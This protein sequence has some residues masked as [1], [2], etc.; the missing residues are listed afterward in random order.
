MTST[1]TSTYHP[2]RTDVAETTAIP[3]TRTRRGWAV[4]GILAGLSGIGTVVS[5]S[6]VDAVYDPGVAG[7]TG[8]IVDKLAT[9]TG[10]ILAF[11]LLS[12]VGALAMIVFGAG[13]QR[14]LRD[15]MADSIVPTVAFAGLLGTA[16][17]SVLGSSLDTE[18]YWGLNQGFV[19]GDPN[20]VF[21]GH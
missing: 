3:T 2:A 4:A 6:M 9:Q 10:Q 14:R 8:A 13:L 1:R 19:D 7:N 5:T 18:Y 15:R 11:H 12:V 21:F 17:V 16:V 20:A